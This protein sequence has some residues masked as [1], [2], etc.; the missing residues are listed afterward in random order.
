MLVGEQ[1]EAP[2]AYVQFPHMNLVRLPQIYRR[3]G[4]TSYFYESPTALYSGTLRVLTSGAVRDYPDV[5]E[6][7]HSD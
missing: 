2:A 5:F 4:R 7:I 6:L 3:T 1:A